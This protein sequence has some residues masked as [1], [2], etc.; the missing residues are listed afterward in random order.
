MK[1]GK[2]MICY[3]TIVMESERHGGIVGSCSI[4]ITHFND[5]RV[6]GNISR[7]LVVPEYPSQSELIHRLLYCIESIAWTQKCTHIVLNSEDVAECKS[8]VQDLDYEVYYKDGQSFFLKLNVD[9]SRFS[10]GH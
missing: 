1:N 4:R 5:E 6:V 2:H 3:K 7:L 8:T 9:Y 10:A